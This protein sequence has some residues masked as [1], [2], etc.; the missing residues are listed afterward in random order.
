MT[1]QILQL[2]IVTQTQQ[3]PELLYIQSHA[4]LFRWYGIKPRACTLVSYLYF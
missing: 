1:W 4:L 3:V 2:Q